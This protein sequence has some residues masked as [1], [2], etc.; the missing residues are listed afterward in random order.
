M[1]AVI[2]GGMPRFMLTYTPESSYAS[3]AQLLFR[4]KDPEDVV[5]MMQDVDTFLADNYPQAST[6]FRRLEIGPSPPAKI[7][8]RFI[9]PDPRCC[10][11]WRFRPRRFSAQIPMQ[12]VSGT[13]GGNAP[14]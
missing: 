5:P 13:T 1:H 2:G 6:K 14:R 7:E 3:Y 11:G 12:S 10:A 9:G 8:A 4:I